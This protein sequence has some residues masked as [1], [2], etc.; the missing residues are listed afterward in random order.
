MSVAEAIDAEAVSVQLRSYGGGAYD[1]AGE[2][3]SSATAISTICAAIQP[4]SGRSL[5][6][7]PEGLREDV[8]LVGWTRSAVAVKDEIVY[9]GE[10]FRVVWV[11]PRPMDGFNKLAMRRVV[12]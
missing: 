10:V 6:D 4:K 12:E 2:W 7:V 3:V 8:E 11:G 1:D 9:G 5:K